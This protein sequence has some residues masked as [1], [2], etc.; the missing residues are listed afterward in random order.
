MFIKVRRISKSS[1]VNLLF[2]FWGRGG[3]VGVVWFSLFLFF[4]TP[5]AC[6]GHILSRRSRSDMLSVWCLLAVPGG[7]LPALQTAGGFAVFFT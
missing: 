6:C 4:V 3:G 5:E 7:E 1:V 2:G